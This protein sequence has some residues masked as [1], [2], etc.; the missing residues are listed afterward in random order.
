MLDHGHRTP[1]PASPADRPAR[2]AC[3]C[4]RAGREQPS[5]SPW[6][7]STGRPRGSSRTGRLRVVQS[8]AGHRP[9]RAIASVPCSTAWRLSIARTRYAHEIVEVLRCC[10]RDHSRSRYEERDN[11][12]A[13]S[14][15]SHPLRHQYGAAAP[16]NG[17][18]SSFWLPVA[19]RRRGR[20]PLREPK[21]AVPQTN[22]T[23]VL[24]DRSLP[25]TRKVATAA[26]VWPFVP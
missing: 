18:E 3:G 19:A 12:R 5:P 15:L 13:T 16:M 8:S 17:R 14:L 2:T 22:D 4:G 26:A 11:S 24:D 23:K 20:S 6:C 9:P 21:T 10:P 7:R 25:L 1:S